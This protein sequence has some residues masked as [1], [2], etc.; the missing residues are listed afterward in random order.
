MGYYS[1]LIY[2]MMLHEDLYLTLKLQSKYL[3]PDKTQLETSILVLKQVQHQIIFS[4]VYEFIIYSDF[5][6]IKQHS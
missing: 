1:Q 5:Y 4:I 2:S 3:I 6:Y